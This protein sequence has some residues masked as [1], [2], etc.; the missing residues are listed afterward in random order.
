MIDDE[1]IKENV[2]DDNEDV[3]IDPADQ[4]EEVNEANEAEDENEVPTLADEAEI[5]ELPDELAAQS[6]PETTEEPIQQRRSGRIPVPMTRFEPSFKGKKYTDTT[7]TT[8][9]QTI[10][11]PDTHLSLTE[12][13]AWDQVV[14][15]TMNQLSLKAGLKRWGTK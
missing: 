15:Y 10:I 12:G 8:I 2:D 7:A 4:D 3:N 9:D 6:V 5:E 13:T 11:H 1:P 14:H